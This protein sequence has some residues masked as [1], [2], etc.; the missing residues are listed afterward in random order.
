MAGEIAMEADSTRRDRRLLFAALSLAALLQVIL[1]LRSSAVS[2]D[3]PVFV[4]MARAL[5]SGPIAAIRA[6]DQHPGYSALLLPAHALFERVA[7]LKGADAWIAA[8][9]L[10]SGL[11]GL[12]TVVAVWLLTRRLFGSRLAGVAAIMA[13][14]VPL[15][16]ESAA[17]VHS[18][19]AHLFFYVLAAWLLLEGLQRRR[20]SWFAAAGLSSAVAY[21]LRPEGLSVALVGAGI[22][23]ILAIRERSPRLIAMF[24]ALVLTAAAGAAP[25]WCAKGVFT[26][27]KDV[28]ALA[29]MSPGAA[30]PSQ[31]ATVASPRSPDAPTP[32]SPLRGVLRLVDRYT[33]E[34]VYVLAVYLVLGIWSRRRARIALTETGAVGALAGF[35]VLL[36]IALFRAA[37]YIDS[38]HVMELIALALPWAAAGLTAAAGWIPAYAQKYCGAWFAR[39]AGRSWTTPAG[40]RNVLL[41]LLVLCLSPW[42]ARTPHRNQTSLVTAS[43]WLRR[44]A[45][46]ADEILTNAPMILFYTGL[47][48]RAVKDEAAL[49]RALEPGFSTARFLALDAHRFAP[50]AALENALK[51]V[52]EPVPGFPLRAGD[53]IEFQLM[54]RR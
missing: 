28:R 22:L 1:A 24:A 53:G 17:D 37:G 16:R 48:G 14:V 29:A 2:L 3:A 49:R 12:L 54:S 42:A 46:P 38:R 30:A 43:S 32:H 11:F 47:P 7:N 41:V 19:T 31:K 40:L 23:A 10:I 44:N 45:R 4:A 20:W 21:W 25:Y 26:S 15:L 9:R 27:K 51:A 52:Y 18:D 6:F 5:R 36:L 35:H 8:G 39:Y 13:A 50:S 33:T 34:M